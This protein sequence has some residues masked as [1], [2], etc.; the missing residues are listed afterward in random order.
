M[1][2]QRAPSFDWVLWLQWL[3]ASTLGWFGGLG[4]FGDV[5]VGTAM[6]VLQW[7]V[8]RSQVPQ[9]GLWVLT[10]TIGWTVGLMILIVALPSEAGLV[11]GPILG[12]VLGFAQWLA[13][14]RWFRHA[15][16]WLMIS[17]LAW[18]VGT[19]FGFIMI[20]AVVGS[21]TGIAVELLLRQY[22]IVPADPADDR[23]GNFKRNSL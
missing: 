1:P 15:G 12:L 6:A 3:L 17:P 7:L 13:L 23:E 22:R 19:L 20:G 16:W 2:D 5:G 4:L 9:A 8:L 11:F 21:V 10:S 18:T 14:K